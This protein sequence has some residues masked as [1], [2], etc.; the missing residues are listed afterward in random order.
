MREAA[1]HDRVLTE[2]DAIDVIDRFAP[3]GTVALVDP[4]DAG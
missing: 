3:L 4:G 1:G 2:G